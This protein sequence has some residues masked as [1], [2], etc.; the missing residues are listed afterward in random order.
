MRPFRIR[1][2][3]ARQ[4]NRGY[5][6]LENSIIQLLGDT[7]FKS[8]RQ[9][10]IVLSRHYSY[11]DIRQQP[12][13]KHRH[14]ESCVDRQPCTLFIF[15]SL[16]AAQHNKTKGDQW[17]EAALE[18]KHWLPDFSQQSSQW[19]LFSAVLLCAIIGA[20]AWLF[21]C[22]SLCMLHLFIWAE[23]WIWTHRAHRWWI[24]GG[25]VCLFGYSEEWFTAFGF[26]CR[27]RK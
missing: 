4:H 11:H 17:D 8:S 16:N 18:L 19:P 27:H 3:C 13:P 5:N 15:I 26:I 22:V 10:S 23:G 1:S 24:A 6:A 21:Y 7:E 12:C 14:Q 9:D 2:W 20:R 25:C